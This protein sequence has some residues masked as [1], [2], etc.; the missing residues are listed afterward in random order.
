MKCHNCGTE[1]EGKFCPECGT[2][3]LKEVEN[4]EPIVQSESVET[5]SSDK[6]TKGGKALLGFRS[7]KIWKKIISVA[8]LVVCGLVLLGT[9]VEGRQGQVTMYDHII[10]KVYSIVLVLTLVSPYIFLSDTKIRNTLPLFKDKTRGKS[11]GGMAIVLV[12][13]FA[14]SG[15]VNGFHSAEYKADMENHAYVVVSSKD[16]DCT[17]PGEVEYYCEY[18]GRTEI[19]TDEALG[20]DMKETS[21]TEPTCTVKGSVLS[22]CSR[23]GTESTSELEVLG[24]NYQEDSRIEPTCTVKGSIL[25][26]CTRCN[27]EETSEIEVLGH[28]IQEDSRTEPTCTTQGSIVGKCQ[29]CNEYATEPIA[30]LG[31]DMKELSRTEP[32]G[33]NDGTITYK[34]SRC[35]H[36]TTETI[37]NPNPKGSKANPYV[38]KADEWH[39]N[40]SN[41]TAKNHLNEYVKVTGTVLNISDYN[42]LKGY[43]LV[44]GPGCGLICWVENGTTSI[45]YGQT[46]EFIG[47]VTV[48]DT[49][50]IEVAECEVLSVQW[51]TEKTK[52][53]ITMSDW[54][55]SRDYVGGVEWS[56][57]FTNNTDKVVKY[58]T[59]K[60]NCYN[61]VGDL[62]RDEITGK[63]SHGVTVTGPLNPRETTDFLCNSTKFYSY[64]FS[65]A[66]L[67][68]M[69]VEFMDGTVIRINDAYTDF[70]VKELTEEYV[71]DS[72]GII[73]V[74]NNETNTCYIES[75]GNYTNTYLGILSSLYGDTVTKIGDSAF[76]NCTTIEKVSI[77][78][79]L[80]CIGDKAFENCTSLVRIDYY[81]TIEAWNA[82]VKGTEW[83]KNTGEYVIYCND[84]QILKDGTVIYD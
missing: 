37:V 18:C 33:D 45:Q 19:K 5:T 74:V 50:H 41:G 84:G 78:Y 7:N 32:S 12:C 28:N 65:K 34:C 66:V 16:A 83:D 59:V 82:I 15:I 10:N 24:H 63:T 54:K 17:T 1:F 31:H 20:H 46:V 62:V 9:L 81:G 49:G 22:K 2:A 61:A 80:E 27:A 30:A 44:G 13:L 60:W 79:A 48:G 70:L 38:Y 26:K 42:T 40:Y 8:Y 29:R 69:V 51:P 52:S 39:K 64:S 67:S 35:T 73:Y 53:P 58:I 68:Y 36:Q 21:R 77:T 76:A 56:F 11:I 25:S 75:A 43:Y 23:C 4:N 14:L 3:A 55:W 72:S 47:K 71:K 6:P 57:R